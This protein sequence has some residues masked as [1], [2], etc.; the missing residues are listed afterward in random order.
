MSKRRS[1]AIT[2][3]QR[4][5]EA[6]KQRGVEA[7]KQRGVVVKKQRSVV[8]KKQ[9]SIET[10][11]AKGRRSEEERNKDSKIKPAL[12]CGLIIEAWNWIPAQK[13]KKEGGQ[14]RSL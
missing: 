13:K 10:V 7:K 14:Q 3:K 11:E 8:V 9:H 5:V 4:S 1:H 2:K 12:V 6:K